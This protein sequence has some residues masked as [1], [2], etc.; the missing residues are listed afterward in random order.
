MFQQHHESTVQATQPQPRR[1][2]RLIL[3]A[4]LGAVLA[5]GLAS[6]ANANPTAVHSVVP[7]TGVTVAESTSAAS[8]GATGITPPT[9]PVG[10]APL[11]DIARY[12]HKSGV[13][14]GGAVSPEAAVGALIPI[15]GQLSAA[16]WSTARG[17]PVWFTAGSETFVATALPDGTWFASPAKFVAC[18]SYAEI[19]K[20]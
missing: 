14:S 12:P 8:I 9:C 20:R 5:L 18:K 1:P 11:L 15:V 2:R 19:Y 7:A 3:G 6:V 13:V 17:A 16:P 10:H 4:G